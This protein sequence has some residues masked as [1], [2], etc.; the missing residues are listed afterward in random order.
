MKCNNCGLELSPRVYDVHVKFC[1]PKEE[2]K[3]EKKVVKKIEKKKPQKNEV[4]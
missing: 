3:E 1:K 4:E 2:K